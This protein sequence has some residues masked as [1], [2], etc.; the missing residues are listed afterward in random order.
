LPLT[1]QSFQ[2][3]AAEYREFEFDRGKDSRLPI[4][5]KKTCETAGRG[6]RFF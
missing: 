1:A 3:S 4:Q 2:R 5:A 6:E